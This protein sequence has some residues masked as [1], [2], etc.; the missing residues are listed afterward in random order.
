MSSPIDEQQV[1]SIAR[2][3]RIRLTD[4]EVATFSQQLGEVLA[5]F[6]KLQQVDIEGVDPM[7][8]A[9]ERTNVLAD[10]EPGQSLAPD[11]ALANA[12]KRHEDVFLVPR[13]LGA[14]S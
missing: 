9:V 2:L 7:P 8:H 11:A 10:D 6:S 12:P 5:A 13:V 4:A 3:S 1:R 14:G